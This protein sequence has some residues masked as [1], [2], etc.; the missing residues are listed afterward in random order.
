MDFT[1]ISKVFM[2]GIGGIGVSALARYFVCKGVEVIGSDAHKS[3]IT[4]DLEKLGV[5]IY[6]EQKPENLNYSA[7]LFVYSSAVPPENVERLRAKELNL[8]QKSYFE[9]LGD[10]S[11]EHNTVAVSGTN[12]KSTTTAMMASCLLGTEHDPMVILG[13][14]HER[15]DRNFHCGTSGLFL[16]EACEYRAHM[17]LLQPKTIV[18]TNIEEDHLDYYKDLNHIK[19][20]FQQYING[21]RNDDDLLILNSDDVNIRDLN[22]P[23]CKTVKFGLIHGSD[24]WA[25][26]IRKLPG[27]QVFNV[28]YYGQDLGD[29]EL[30]VP[31]DFNI[32]NALAAVAYALSLNIPVGQI[33]E[34]I[35]S[36]KGI[37]R[38]FELIKS[39]PY[40][41]VSDYAHHPTAVESTIKG[42]REFFPGRRIVTV[43]QPHQ[44]DRTKKL[45]DEFV[46][47]FKM[48]DVTILPEIY[49]VAGREE[50]IKVSSQDLVDKIQEQDV[51]K[52]VVF[53]KDLSE[54]TTKAK[55]LI[56]DEDVVLVMGAG[57]I[58]TIVNNL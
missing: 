8:P 32:Y 45:F 2:S 7:D 41:V 35:R 22:L 3:E 50:D 34:S 29:F 47:S 6:Y 15:L 55:E 39:D 21:L 57:D 49:D 51:N 54:A 23:K 11:R 38:R 58:Y 43:F 1:K 53:A 44:K 48:S 9:V 56:K 4:E 18:L 40:T 52:T 42:A 33:R 16:V 19:Q 17:L 10:L 28:V 14:C 30:N 13:S 37:W 24:V 26:N 25:Q 5:K 36:F 27:K 31:G 12:G 46:A 20:T